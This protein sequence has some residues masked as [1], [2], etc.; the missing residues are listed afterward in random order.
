MNLH[1]SSEKYIYTPEEHDAR[2]L[3]L[4][5]LETEGRELNPASKRFALASRMEIN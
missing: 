3:E 4:I 5:Q 2:L 1:Q